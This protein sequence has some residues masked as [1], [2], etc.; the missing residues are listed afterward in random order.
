MKLSISKKI[1]FI[2]S[3][4]LFATLSVMIFVLITLEG[5]SKIDIKR[6]N[7]SKRIDTTVTKSLL[8][9]RSNGKIVNH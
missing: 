7:N 3:I 5:N 4:C 9:V 1:G 2:V 8:T 6:E